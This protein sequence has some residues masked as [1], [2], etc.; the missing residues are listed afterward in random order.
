MSFTMPGNH[1]C[2]FLQVAVVSPM[3]GCCSQNDD[4]PLPG[5]G[6]IV[7]VSNPYVVFDTKHG[8]LT[9]PSETVPS[10]DSFK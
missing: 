8:F 4:N 10:S 7:Y 9:L 1:S 2:L 3:K 6:S 5:S